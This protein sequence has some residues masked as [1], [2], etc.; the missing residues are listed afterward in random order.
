M[1]FTKIISL[2]LLVVMCLGVFAACGDKGNTNQG[3]DDNKPKVT[4]TVWA[5]QE[6]QAMVKEMC[7]AYAAAN[8]DK[9]YKFLFGIQGEN[10]AADK[11]LNDVTSGPD[12]F[13]FASDQINKLYTGGALARL[14][15]AILDEVKA[16]NTADSVD[17]AT[18]TIGGEDQVYA[19][20]M[21]GDN[22]FYVYYDKRVYTDAT[23]L[24]TLDGLI[25]GAQANQMNVQFALTNGWYL[26]SF[27]FANPDLYYKVNYDDNLVE[28]SVEINFNNADGLEVARSVRDYYYGSNGAFVIQTDDAKIT[29]GF[30]DGTTAAAVSG[31]W[32]LKTFQGLLG[33]NLGVCI[34]PKVKI[35]GEYVQLSG[36]TGYKLIGV[37]NF[38]GNKGEAHKLALWLTN[39]ANQIKR[40]EVR[41]FGPTN[42]N[43]IATDAVQNDPVISVILRQAALNRPQKGVPSNFWTATEAL[44]LPFIT[45]ER[46]LQTDEKLQ[47]MLDACVKVIKKEA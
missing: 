7:D 47:E 19:Y 40:H 12:V 5:S 24:E 10:D 31:I 44:F 37:N 6:D 4:L 9:T 28:Q 42:K 22:N 1:K 35:G 16:N 46:D 11:V 23:Q 43:A 3:G 26:S 21:T 41:G 32:N 20:P 13:S 2:L 25:A 18:L 15:G 14:G 39:E 27:F 33:D 8:P 36:F 45:E 30:T 38:S 29:A 17:A 34:L